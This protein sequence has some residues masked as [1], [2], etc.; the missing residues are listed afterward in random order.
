MEHGFICFPIKKEP[1]FHIN[2]ESANEDLAQSIVE[3]FES[4][5]INWLS[6][7]AGG[8]TNK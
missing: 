1:L 4:K 2:A 8:K 7:W 3:S 5:I 6:D